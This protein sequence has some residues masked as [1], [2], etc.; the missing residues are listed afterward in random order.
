MFAFISYNTHWNAII[1]PD[2]TLLVRR[3]I[4]YWGV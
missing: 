1:L 3:T 4:C 2:H